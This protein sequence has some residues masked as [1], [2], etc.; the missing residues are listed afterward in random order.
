VKLLSQDALRTFRGTIVDL[1][2]EGG[3]TLDVVDDLRDAPL[4]LL[5]RQVLPAGERRE[6]DRVRRGV[7]QPF[8]GEAPAPVG[9]FPGTVEPVALKGLFLQQCADGGDS[10]PVSQA[11]DE[12]FLAAMRQDV[13]QPLDLGGLL[14]ADRDGLVAPPPELL[15]PVGETT[16]LPGEVR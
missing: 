5:T 6:V 7:A 11:L 15:A 9:V 16:G 1:A 12:R 14:F 13:P 2:P 4:V 8:E 10:G 3:L